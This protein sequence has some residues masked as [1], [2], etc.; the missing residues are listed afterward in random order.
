M[1][2]QKILMKK[3][4]AIYQKKRSEITDI[5]NLTYNKPLNQSPCIITKDVILNGV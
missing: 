1:E 3:C 5:F 2:R 4:P